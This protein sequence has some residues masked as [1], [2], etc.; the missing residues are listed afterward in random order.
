MTYADRPIRGLLDGIASEQVTP[1]GGTAAALA[2]ALGTALCEMACLHTLGVDGY[3][4]VRAEMIE[5][6]EDLG[7]RRERL[8]ALADR[9][10]AAVEDLFDADSGEADAAAKRAA[11]VPLAVAEACLPVLEHAAAA[12]DRGN[13]NAVPDAVTGAF[14][15]HSALRASVATVRSNLDRIPDESFV[16]EMEARTAELEQSATA[17]LDRI[18]AT[19][20]G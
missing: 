18:T 6:R 15:V 7:T 20:D 1:A 9:D 8:L 5:R 10:A 3:A 17:E 2:A 19:L 14:L 11:G 12:V 4:D 13:R 16:T